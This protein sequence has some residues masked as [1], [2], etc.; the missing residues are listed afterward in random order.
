MNIR[1]ALP[2]GC[3]LGE[4]PV[5]DGRTGTLVFVDIKDPA[6]WRFVPNK[7]WATR[8]PL[9]ERIG[10]VALTTDPEVYVLG[11][12]QG[13]VLYR[14]TDGRQHH[15]VDP[16]PDLPGNR[17]NDG[18]VDIDGAVIFGTMDDAEVQP[19][20]S[21]WRWHPDEG[22][23]RIDTGYIVSNGPVAH[24]DGQR[25]LVIDSVARQ[26]KAFNRTPRGFGPPRAFFEW[27]ARWGYPDGMVA[28][29][30]GNLWVA[31]W[32]GAAVTKLSPHGQVLRRLT[33][34]A[35]NVTKPCFGGTD[36]AT[37]FLTTAHVGTDRDAYPEAGHV[38]ALE[39][40]VRGLP[41]QIA[42]I[43]LHEAFR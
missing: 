40:D 24:P 25:L 32:A 1:T 36:L 35:L 33:V 34:P 8:R 15:L 28:D 20:G 42:A 41:A 39:P 21:F 7:G 12:K 26:I 23:T 17:I 9:P 22:L 6:L 37:L 27:P 29:A 19:S 16:E 14:W 5:W 11:L 3:L 18:I 2:S 31:H 10:F 13:L 38:F 43:K 4:G 30:E